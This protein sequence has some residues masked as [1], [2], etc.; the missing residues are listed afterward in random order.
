MYF[1]FRKPLEVI[2]MIMILQLDENHQDKKVRLLL[3]KIRRGCL[4]MVMKITL[5]HRRA[6]EKTFET[7]SV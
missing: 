6:K 7:I 4:I 2:N 5:S 1:L 3:D